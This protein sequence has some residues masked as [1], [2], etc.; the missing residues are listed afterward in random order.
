MTSG[1][2]VWR[3]LDQGRAMLSYVA[4]FAWRLV[5]S[6]VRGFD[7][8][9]LLWP[10]F[11]LTVESGNVAGKL[12]GLIATRFYRRNPYANPRLNRSE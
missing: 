12:E 6:L 5:S 11:L 10:L 1:R 3:M 4:G 7:G 2:Q 8:R 9:Y